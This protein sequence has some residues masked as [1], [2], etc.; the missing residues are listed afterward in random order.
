MFDKEKFN[1][2][3]TKNQTCLEKIEDRCN[4]TKVA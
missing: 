3:V 1:K 2:D 4:K